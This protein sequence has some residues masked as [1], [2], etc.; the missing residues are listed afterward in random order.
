MSD[1]AQHGPILTLPCL[2]TSSAD[3][4]EHEVLP[5]LTQRNPVALILPC[6]AAD[7]LADPLRQIL[8]CLEKTIW[9]QHILVPVNGLSPEDFKVAAT[10]LLNSYPQL[11]LTVLHTDADLP[12]LQPGKGSNVLNALRLLK[13]QSFTGIVALQD[14]DHVSFRSDALA[15]LVH[16]VVDRTFGLELAKQFYSRCD[17]R[18]HGRVSRLFLAPLLETLTTTLPA[19]LARFLN[20]FRYPLAGECALSMRFAEHIQIPAGWGLEIAL[21]TEAHRILSPE[22]VCQ[23]GSPRPHQHRHHQDSQHL[24]EQCRAI[25]NTLATH[26]SSEGKLTQE[27]LLNLQ[28]LFAQAQLRALRSSSLVARANAL[29]Y[30]T[31]SEFELAALVSTS[32]AEPRH[33]PVLNGINDLEH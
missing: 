4:L 31:E 24:L 2:E 8:E 17:H 27:A 12:Q 25:L 18:L 23:V 16:P 22:A 30:D 20:A 10:A 7:A 13:S 14:A 26:P 5:H 19:N 1:F 21:L 6:I 29:Q 32:L 11:P 9:I 15:R 3:A 28:P 33:S